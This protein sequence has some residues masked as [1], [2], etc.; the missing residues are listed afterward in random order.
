MFTFNLPY[1]NVFQDVPLVCPFVCLYSF[2]VRFKYPSHVLLHEEIHRVFR[3][4]R[5]RLVRRNVRP[6]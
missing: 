4:V 1:V 3:L 2:Q 6:M 5:V